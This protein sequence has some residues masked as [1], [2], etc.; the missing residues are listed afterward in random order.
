MP[1]ASVKTNG[2][3]RLVWA[4]NFLFG[5]LCFDAAM[6]F[7][8]VRKAL[9]WAGILRASTHG[10]VNIS[11]DGEQC[12]GLSLAVNLLI[13]LLL[14]AVFVRQPSYVVSFLKSPYHCWKWSSRRLV[15]VRRWASLSNLGLGLLGLIGSLYLA[16]FVLLACSVILNGLSGLA[17]LLAGKLNPAIFRTAVFGLFL[18]NSALTLFLLEHDIRKKE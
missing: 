1:D 16:M 10:G 14:V 11:W 15:L 13:T 8:F 5:L 7:D 2:L 9:Q 18:M 3:N 4:T 6:S 17:N 12:E